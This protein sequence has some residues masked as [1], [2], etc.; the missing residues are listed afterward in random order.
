MNIYF[1]KFW[2]YLFLVYLWQWKMNRYPKVQ[3][4]C[5]E[6]SN[7]CAW[8]SKR[9]VK[10]QN[11]IRY[12]I[13]LKL[14]KECPRNYLKLLIKI[15][16][17]SLF[18]FGLYKITKKNEFNLDIF[19]SIKPSWIRIIIVIEIFFFLSGISS[20]FDPTRSFSYFEY[21]FELHRKTTCN[22]K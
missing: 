17:I 1:I 21:F 5:K 4:R 13:S 22:N 19:L 9:K 3:Q 15:K 8:N 16:N 12:K 7:F 2:L 10:L 11:K 18:I 14:A 20:F 6:I